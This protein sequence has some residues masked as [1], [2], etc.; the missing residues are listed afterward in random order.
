MTTLGVTG[1]IGSG[2]SAACRIFEELG[3]RVVYADVEAKQLMHQDSA[4]RAAITEA[5]GSESYDAEGRLNRPHLAAR[6]FGDA[7]QV[8]RLNALVHP[9]VRERML[10]LIDKARADG[11]DLLVY[12]AALLFETGADRV[13][14]HVAVVDAPIDTRIA[15]VVERDGVTREA[16]LARMQHQLP[17]A[18][19]RR[20][21]DFV[22]EN[23][24]DLT[25]LRAQVEALYR[26]FTSAPA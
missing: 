24:G 10:A 9:R 5:F 7:T 6:V 12:E 26:R 25:H 20:R 11:T 21:A 1:G 15:R 13:L 22:I 18:D 2:K 8:A 16:V 3:A 23:D 14:D 17:A 4:L 19:L